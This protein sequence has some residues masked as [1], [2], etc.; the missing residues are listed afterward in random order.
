MSVYENTPAGEVRRAVAAGAFPLPGDP[1][2]MA[3]AMI[4]SVDIEPAPLRLT[5]GSD[6]YR[7][8]RAAL[9]GRLAALDAQRDVALATD[10]TAP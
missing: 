5:L 10:I 3:Q 1:D 6:A 8:V 7:D 4:D 2:K 9:A